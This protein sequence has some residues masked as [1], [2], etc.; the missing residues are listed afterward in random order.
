MSLELPVKESVGILFG[1]LG[2]EWLLF[3]HANF[4]VALGLAFG[5]SLLIFYWRRRKSRRAD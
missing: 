4:L 1:L 2:L 5:F 3:G